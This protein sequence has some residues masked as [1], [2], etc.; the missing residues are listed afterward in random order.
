MSNRP[1]LRCQLTSCET[2]ERNPFAYGAGHFSEIIYQCDNCGKLE[3]E[4][5]V[6]RISPGSLQG[7]YVPTENTICMS[8]RAGRMR[9]R[10]L[11]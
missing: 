10:L 9:R 7:N 8:C 11:R 5:T 3:Q 1:C 4:P 6:F 2:C